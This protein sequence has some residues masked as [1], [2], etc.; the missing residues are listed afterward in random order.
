MCMMHQLLCGVPQGSILG[1]ILFFIYI[2]D[3]ATLASDLEFEYHGYADDAQ[4]Y[5]H[6][7]ADQQS[8]ASTAL[9]FQDCIVQILNWM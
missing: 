8:I 4:V 6:F 5:R 2:K 3:A 9:K 7:L 1:P